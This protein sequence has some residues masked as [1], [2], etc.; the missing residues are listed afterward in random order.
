MTTTRF[1]RLS[2]AA[3]REAWPDEARDFTP[4][5]FDNIGFLSGAVGIE[6]KAIATEAAV[7]NFS[8]DIIAEDS[9]TGERVLIENQL[10]AS[11][12]R[13]LGQVLTYLAGIKARSVIWIARDF[14][15]A[16]R[17]AVRWLNEHTDDD[18]AFFAVRLRVVR[19]GDSPFAPVFDVVEQP[20]DWDTT[21]RSNTAAAESEL[22]GL[23]RRFWDRYLERHPGVFS[24]SR[25][26]NVW[27]PMLSDG[28]VVLSMY[29]GSKTSGMFLRGR[30]GTDGEHLA[31]YMSRHA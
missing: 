1:T 14:Q 18:F 23:R 25:H 15:D 6:L 3:I 29:V 19:I 10:E 27:V 8:V 30:F 20:N 4:W 7:D 13:H 11:D 12:H 22:T 31:P 5:L 17:S 26:S 16:H 28:E 9:R 21:L 2:D 24:P